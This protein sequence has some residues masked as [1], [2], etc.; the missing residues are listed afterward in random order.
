MYAILHLVA[1]IICQSFAE[2]LY[3]GVLEY[4]FL[5]GLVFQLRQG[6]N[7]VGEVEQGLHLRLTVVELLEG[8][9]QLGGDVADELGLQGV[10]LVGQFDDLLRDPR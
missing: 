1:D 8:G 2:R 9:L 3:L 7:V 6:L 4:D 10:A 5:C